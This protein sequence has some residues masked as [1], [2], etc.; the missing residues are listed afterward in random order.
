MRFFGGSLIVFGLALSAATAPPNKVVISASSD[1][2]PKYDTLYGVTATPYTTSGRKS[3]TSKITWSVGASGIVQIQVLDTKGQHA[4]FIGIS[5][6]AV[7]IYAT[8]KLSSG[9]IVRDTLNFLVKKPSVAVM[10]P[11]LSF[12]QDGSINNSDTLIKILVDSANRRTIYETRCVW[13]VTYDR[14]GAV[15]TGK[16]VTFVTNNPAIVTVRSGN[17]CPDTSVNPTALPY[18]TP[19]PPDDTVPFGTALRR[20][21]PI[22]KPPFSRAG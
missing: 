8:W 6:G 21:I 4:N 22:R 12:N 10:R 16:P 11:A 9:L 18:P 3:T 17:I 15:V 5:E 19:K 20:G 13:G 7:P 14:R 1:T 2:L